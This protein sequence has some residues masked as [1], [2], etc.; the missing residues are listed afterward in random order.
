MNK[1]NLPDWYKKYVNLV[2]KSIDRYL[3]T[4][5]AIPMWKPLNDFKEIIKYSFC[6]GKKLRA[7]LALEFYL[8]LS[9]KSIDDIRI[10][11]DIIRVCT[12]IEAIHAYSLI[13]DDLPC[14]DNDELRRG[15]PTVWKKF[16]EYNAV[17]VGDLLNSLCFEI[18]SDIKDPVISQKVLKLLSHSVWFYGMIWWQIED[19]YYEHNIADL[20]VDTLRWLHAKKTWKLIEASILSWVI[21]SGEVS[22]I[23]IYWDFGKKLGLA[24]QI[25]DDLL[26]VEWTPEE[27]GKSVWWEEKGFVYLLWVSATKKILHDM[28]EECRDIANKLWSEK[29]DFIVHYMENRTK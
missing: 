22:N 14:M 4:Y 27:T 7:I 28:I 13:H 29:I 23:D 17:L 3:D 2:E 10:D 19:L 6:G 12:A 18:I 20:D 11:D 21:L 24:F 16:W 15:E 1:K 25:K 26:D 9:Q 8:T 5:L